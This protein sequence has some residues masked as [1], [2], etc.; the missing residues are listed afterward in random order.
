MLGELLKKQDVRVLQAKNRIVMIVYGLALLLSPI[1][2]LKVFDI[3]GPAPVLAIVAGIILSLPVAILNLRK[4]GEPSD[5]LI[6]TLFAGVC[7]PLTG[8]ILWRYVNDLSDGR[9]VV[10]TYRSWRY[11]AGG[12]CLILGEVWLYW[13]G[14]KRQ[15]R[16]YSSVSQTVR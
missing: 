5:R 6:A 8:L 4:T 12:V 1:G 16:A 2:L 15:F 13:H 9:I 14:L 10:N 7:L 11:A 3:Y